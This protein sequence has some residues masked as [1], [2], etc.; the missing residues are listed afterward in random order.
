MFKALMVSLKA[1]GVFALSMMVMMMAGLTFGKIA[2]TAE[3]M[4]LLTFFVSL[5]SGMITIGSVFAMVERK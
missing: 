5:P 3:N 1:S 2:P 4:G